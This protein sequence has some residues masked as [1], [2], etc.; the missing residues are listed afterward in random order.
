MEGNDIRDNGDG[1]FTTTQANETFS[2]L[3]RYIMGFLPPGAVPRTFV[4]TGN[5][6]PGRPPEPGVVIRGSKVEVSVRDIIR[7]EG[8]R[9][10]NSAQSQK[11]FRE[12]FILF[13]R[14]DTP[15][16]AALNKLERIR[17]GWTA[18]WRKETGNKS[19]MDTTLP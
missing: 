19:T 9:V 6:D 17:T 13:T 11:K 14:N 15:S 5:S 18:F 1:T 3:D 7:I 4:V 10:P 2:K 16:Q 8:A 12:A